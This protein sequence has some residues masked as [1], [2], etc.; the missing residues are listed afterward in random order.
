MGFFSERDIE[1]QELI[2][3]GADRELI[4]ALYPDMERDE[5]DMYFGDDADYDILDA[6]VISYDDLV[7]EPEWVD[8]EG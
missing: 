3:N 8:E 2:Y 6:D 1:I 7:N 5:L 4:L